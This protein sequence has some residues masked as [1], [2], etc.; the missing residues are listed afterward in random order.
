MGVNWHNEHDY[1]GYEGIAWDC[2]LFFV[3]DVS[4]EDQYFDLDVEDDEGD[5][6]VIA[7]DRFSDRM[8]VDNSV[9]S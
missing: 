1:D 8:L 7:L 5:W 4:E 9:K 6:Q 2:C 3:P